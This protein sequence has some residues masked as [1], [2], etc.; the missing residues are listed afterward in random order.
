MLFISSSV[1]LLVQALCLQLAAARILVDRGNSAFDYIVV[2]GGN[3]GLT[4][5]SRLSEDAQVRVA[6]IEAGNFYEEVTGN[7]SQIPANDALYNG[8]AANNT[9]PLVEW[10]FMTTPQAVSR[11]HL[12]PS[13]TPGW[14]IKR[15][16]SRV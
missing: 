4:I 2:G 15:G 8:K 10:G 6:V 14:A 1:P 3:A 5:A 13:C 7:Q 9:N 11:S 16:M 12:T